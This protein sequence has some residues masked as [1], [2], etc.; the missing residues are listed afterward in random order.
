MEEAGGWGN[1]EWKLG[2]RRLNWA[3]YG[4]GER[5]EGEGRGQRVGVGASCEREM[6]QNWEGVEI[7]RE[8]LGRECRLRGDM[9]KGREI[10][11]EW[12]FRGRDEG[13]EWGFRGRDV[14]GNG[15]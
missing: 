9:G 8:I 3:G 7:E 4:G 15:Y 10:G 13:K 1:G 12:I 11:R 14:E 6:W 2:R 5:G